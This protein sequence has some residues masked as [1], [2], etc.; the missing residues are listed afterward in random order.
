MKKSV[1]A[2]TRAL[3]FSM[4]M[5][6]PGIAISDE[7]KREATTAQR[8][9]VVNSIAGS[10]LTEEQPADETGR[11]EWTGA[12]RFA[13]TRVYIQKAPWEVG[14]ESWWR[15]KHRRDGTTAHRLL[16]E[17]EIG[18]PGRMQLDLYTDHEGSNDG[19]FH[20]QSFNA[21]LRYALAD[22]GKIWGNPTL[23]AE[24]KFADKHWGPDV[25]EC[26]LLLGDQL[27]P[28]WH[29]GV[30][31]V[32]EAEVGG[33]REQEFQVTTGLS[34]TVIDGKLGV[35]LE[36]FY[37]RDSVKNA[38]GSASD[39]FAVGPSIQWRV[40]KNIHVDLNCMSG[41]NK[42]SERQIGYLVIGY[43][44]GPGESKKH[45]YTPISGQRN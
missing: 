14:V 11:P 35:G 8:M 22:W 6:L 25:Y 39:I 2:F 41:T 31:F 43:D 38:R 42:A 30:N 21:E 20:F 1:P 18:L 3:L 9:P 37:D 24:Y 32:W 28:R 17:V 23:Y 45:G 27:A 29:W 12:R 7:A 15:L 5:T 16:Q 10:L 34:Y 13:G 4:S 33:E 44:F 40:T 19:R 26:K 36:T